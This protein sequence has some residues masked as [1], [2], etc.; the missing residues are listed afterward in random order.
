MKVDTNK[1]MI[2]IIIIIAIVFAIYV[3][4]NIG[5]I[6]YVPETNNVA[7]YGYDYEAGL[8]EA[9]E[10]LDEVAEYNDTFYASVLAEGPRNEYYSEAIEWFKFEGY[11]D[12]EIDEII[13]ELSQNKNVYSF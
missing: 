13:Y 12:E 10:M 11:S 4:S 6:F 5:D 2:F 1:V 3:V 8:E 9:Y 7:S